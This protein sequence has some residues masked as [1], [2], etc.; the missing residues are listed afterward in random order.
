[1]EIGQTHEK[2]ARLAADLK[3]APSRF[4]EWLYVGLATVP[5]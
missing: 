4:L 1:M 3:P 5:Q 2:A